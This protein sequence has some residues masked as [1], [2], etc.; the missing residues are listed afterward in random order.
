MRREFLPFSPPDIPDE[1]IRAVEELLRSDWPTTGARARQFEEEFAAYVGSKAALAVSSGTAAMQVSLAAF[2]V[3]AGDR[4]ATTPLTFCAT[5]HVIEHMGARPVFVDV[6]PETLDISPAELERALAREKFAAIMPVHL[7]G[8]PCDMDPIFALARSHGC[9]VVEDA[10]HAF[11]ATYR[12]GHVGSL[13]ER[14]G[15]RG[16]ACFSFYATKNITTVEGGMVTGDADFI[17]EARLWS[18]HGIDRD[19][20]ARQHGGSSWGYEVVRPGFKCN[21]PDISAVL[22]LAQ[23]Q[24]VRAMQQRRREIVARYDEAFGQVPGLQL[25]AN[26][27][28]V[29]H[30]WQLYA[31]RLDPA[32]FRWEPGDCQSGF[33]EALKDRNIGASVHFVPLHLQPYY[34]DRYGLR[35]EDFPVADRESRRLVSLPLF[36]R[37]T[38]VDIQDVIEAVVDVVARNRR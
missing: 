4:V 6:D 15:A 22:G 1:G 26:R 8:H 17:A 30:A 9:V 28:E 13:A 11:P 35:P 24:R 27:P 31:L 16:S 33:I 14:A 7:Y 21:M 36:T 29:G 37:M 3:R 38:D 23:L 20:W 2:G 10:A 5:A 18:L 32:A 12:D 34:R 25:P 19:T